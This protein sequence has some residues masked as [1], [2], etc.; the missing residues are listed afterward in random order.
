MHGPPG[1]NA[2]AGGL[3][4][5]DDEGRQVGGAEVY[6]AALAHLWHQI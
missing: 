6:R 2:E 1:G 4:P 3:Q 5:H